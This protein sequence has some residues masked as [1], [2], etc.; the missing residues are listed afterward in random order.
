VPTPEDTAAEA[1][2][3]FVKIEDQTM[4]DDA[5]DAYAPYWETSFAVRDQVIRAE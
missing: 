3:K 5:Y 1:I 2:G 4:L